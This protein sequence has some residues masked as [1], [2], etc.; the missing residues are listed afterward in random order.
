MRWMGLRMRTMTGDEKWHERNGKWAM[1]GMDWVGG[2]RLLFVGLGRDN[3]WEFGIWVCRYMRRQS[4]GVFWFLPHVGVGIKEW[5][6]VV[7]KNCLFVVIFVMHV[8][9]IW[10]VV[11]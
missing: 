9:A 4:N 3:R 7:F 6:F 8:N 11:A 2:L 10:I 1:M 5:I